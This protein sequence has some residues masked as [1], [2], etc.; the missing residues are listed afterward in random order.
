MTGGSVFGLSED[1][2]SVALGGTIFRDSEYYLIDRKWNGFCST[3]WFPTCKPL[4]RRHY[5]SE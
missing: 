2:W 4:L 5:V 3:S 1:N